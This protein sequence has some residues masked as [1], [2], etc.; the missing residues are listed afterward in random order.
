MSLDNKFKDLPESYSREVQYC[1]YLRPDILA[2]L[3]AVD[4]Y[5]QEQYVQ[6]ERLLHID[7][8]LLEWVNLGYAK[9]WR[10]D[11]EINGKINE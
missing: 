4:Q 9:A 7:E 5:R 10:E 6:H 1:N 11:Y 2:Q 8:A 3:R